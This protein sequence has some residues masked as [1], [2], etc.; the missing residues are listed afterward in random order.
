[1]I[2]I[3]SQQSKYMKLNNNL[4]GVLLFILAGCSDETF[5]WSVTPIFITGYLR[6]RI[7]MGYYNLG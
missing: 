1:M 5:S 3:Q 6:Y 7:C 2:S 4:A